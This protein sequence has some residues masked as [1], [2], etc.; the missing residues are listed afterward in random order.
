MTEGQVAVRCFAVGQSS[1]PLA[2]ASWEYT[3]KAGA[4]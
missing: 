4:E 1:V 3:Q 2:T